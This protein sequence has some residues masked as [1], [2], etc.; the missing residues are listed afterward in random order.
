M[1]KLF[2]ILFLFL[3]FK[4]LFSQSIVI[5]DAGDGWRLKV[6]M[7]LQ[8]IETYDYDKYEKLRQACSRISYWNGNYSTT[9]GIDVIIISSIEMNDTSIQNIAAVIIH[10][11]YHLMKKT[12]F[13]KNIYV[14]EYEAYI[15]EL[16]FLSRL[17]NPNKN[18]LNH[19]IKMALYYLDLDSKQ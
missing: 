9:E 13:E 16:D 11:S 3:F 19:C 4:N 17:P 1:K 2:T 18:L 12:E 15:Y 5:D 10:E 6:E 7:A 8:L 14:E